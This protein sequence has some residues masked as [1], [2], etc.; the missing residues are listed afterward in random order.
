MVDETTTTTRLGL[1]HVVVS[2]EFGSRDGHNGRRLAATRR[3]S[4]LFLNI[5]CKNTHDD[6][7]EDERML[8]DSSRVRL[9]SRTFYLELYTPCSR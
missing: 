2:A 5:L 7:D 8:S 4:K 9:S 1:L 6:D 3:V